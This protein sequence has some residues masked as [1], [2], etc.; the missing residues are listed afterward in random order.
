MAGTWALALEQE[1]DG[2]RELS[3]AINDCEIVRTP[4]ETSS[5]SPDSV[6]SRGVSTWWA[7]VLQAAARAQPGWED[8]A[9][10]QM[11]AVHV[12]SACAGSC[13]EAW[14]L[15]ASR[16]SVALV[17]LVAAASAVA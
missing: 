6:A 2:Q 8:W 12:V 1:L 16:I 7:A 3:D 4:S 14:V 15:K 13:A 5:C 11:E 9:N 17:A 10:S